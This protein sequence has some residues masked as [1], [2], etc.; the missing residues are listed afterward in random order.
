VRVRYT[1]WG[2]H[3]HWTFDVQPLGEDE[4]GHWFGAR[5]GTPQQRA[6]EPP[7]ILDHDCVMLVPRAGEYT[8]FWNAEDP[9]ELYVDV[10]TRPTIGSEVITAVD[11]DLDVVRF[12]DGKVELLDEDEFLDHQV[13]YAY[14]ASLVLSARATADWLLSAVTTRIEPFNIA[15]PTWLTSLQAG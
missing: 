4:H 3:P 1:K 5:R 8:A 11:L 12:R 14:P 13:R 15:G 7:V 6:S 2:D 9:I 10:T